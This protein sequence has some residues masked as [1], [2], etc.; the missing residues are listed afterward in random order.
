MLQADAKIKYLHMI[1][2]GEA[3]IY[4]DVLSVEVE[5]S[6]LEIFSYIILDLVAYLFLG[7]A[8]SKKKNCDAPQSEEAA[9]FKN[10][11]LYHSFDWK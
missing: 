6:S 11:T 5:S 10:E 3:L 4:F 9:R 7:N 1:V 2:Q 8:M